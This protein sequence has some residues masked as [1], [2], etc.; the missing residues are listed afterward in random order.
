[1]DRAGQRRI[2][3]ALVLASADP[4]A[5]AR[6]AAI[7]PDSTPG[8]VRERVA[9]LNDAYDAQGRAFR[10]EEV[11]GGFQL[12]TRPEL[13]AYLQELR[14]ERPLRLSRA[15]LETLAIVAY[16]QPTTRAEVEQVRGVEAGAVLRTLLERQLLRIAGHREV[17]G[18]PLLYTTTR[19]FL[20]LFGL[21]SLGDLPTLRQIEDLL[22]ETAPAASA[23]AGGD[24]DDG[25]V[26]AGGGSPGNGT[27][28]TCAAEAPGPAGEPH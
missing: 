10:I 6:L 27:G 8:S 26:E 3:E 19:R 14:P 12:R 28:E 18:R 13:A 4:I 2:L 21:S 20:E 5:A 11:A 16:R 15:A 7:V 9:E 23:A 22:P 24:A 25:S 1:M 17:P